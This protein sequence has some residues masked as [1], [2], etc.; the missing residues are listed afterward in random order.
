MLVWK[1]FIVIIRFWEL[2]SWQFWLSWRSYLI[3]RKLL[4]EIIWNIFIININFHNLVIIR[5]RSKVLLFNFIRIIPWRIILISI[6][7][8]IV[9]NSC[10][11]PISL[12]VAQEVAF[13]D[14]G[15]LLAFIEYF[16]IE[17]KFNS[18]KWFLLF[19]GKVVVVGNIS[20]FGFLG[21]W[22]LL[23]DEN[24][25]SEKLVGVEFIGR[26]WILINWSITRL[27]VL[28]ISWILHKINRIIIIYSHINLSHPII[29]RISVKHRLHILLELLILLKLI[30][31]RLLLRPKCSIIMHINV[32][33]E[34]SRW[35]LRL[36]AR[37]YWKRLCCLQIWFL[38]CCVESRACVCLGVGKCVWICI[39]CWVGV[40][41]S[42]CWLIGG[43]R[44][45]GGSRCCLWIGL[46]IGSSW[47]LGISVC[48]CGR[49]EEKWLMRHWLASLLVMHLTVFSFDILEM[50]RLIQMMRIWRLSGWDDWRL[51]WRN[52]WN[53]MHWKWMS[54][55]VIACRICC[56]LHS[57]SGCS[58]LDIRIMRTIVKLHTH[59]CS[60]VRVWGIGRM[61]SCGWSCG[62]RRWCRSWLR[63]SCW[64]SSCWSG[65]SRSWSCC[66][67]SWRR[68]YSRSR[69]CSCCRSR[70]RLGSWS[71]WSL[72]NRGRSCSCVWQRTR[73]SCYCCSISY[74][75]RLSICS[76]CCR[77]SRRRC[78][79]NAS[80][81]NLYLFL[82]IIIKVVVC[83]FRLRLLFNIIL[84]ILGFL[85]LG[86]FLI[87]FLF[88]FHIW[89]LDR[90]G[91]LLY[92]FWFLF[93][94]CIR[95]QS[96]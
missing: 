36:R 86:I 8:S 6:Y 63:S 93:L 18:F 61:R 80:M 5:S 47:S 4:H 75:S 54:I 51:S 79:L 95:D 21:V 16:W 14:L 7:I 45:V 49:V 85:F 43:W 20:K 11:S 35:L 72:R 33:W 65:R 25:V 67:R 9:I 28:Q 69:L 31:L 1:V 73:S 50:K 68:C 62:S 96:L 88:F 42:V 22:L 52:S 46:C 71:R 70:C 66:C 57:K 2:S 59:C 37:N 23:S 10:L 56:C 89:L 26:L 17:N 91:R 27:K 19:W 94:L 38:S 40:G 87:V 60:W 30:R 34:T 32:P 3:L 92:F 48:G 55:W 15:R 90:L 83:R 39:C 41:V 82:F 58:L 78:I 13:S 77:S 29:L 81:F 53:W 76:S 84:L 44:L 12:I 64:L 74:L 24:I